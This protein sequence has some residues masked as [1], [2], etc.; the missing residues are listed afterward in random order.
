MLQIPIQI[1][2]NLANF[3]ADQE[4]QQFLNLNQMEMEQR[5]QQQEQLLL[6][7]GYTETVVLAYQKIMMQVYLAQEIEEMNLQMGEVQPALQGMT[8]AEAV[9]FLTQ[10]HLLETSEI[11]QLFNLLSQLELS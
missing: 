9:R 7:K 2:H 11:N 6:S 10:D 3:V 5:L 8:A 1:W 4:D